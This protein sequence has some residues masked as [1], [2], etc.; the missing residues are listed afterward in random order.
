MITMAE[1]MYIKQLY[2]EGISK[3]EISKRTKLN[4]RTVSK[5]AEKRI[6]MI[7]RCPVLTRRTIRFSVNIYRSSTNGSKETPKYQESSVIRQNV[8]T[9]RLQEEYGY[10]GGYGSVK[11]Y[12]RK[13]RFVMHYEHTGCLPLEHPLISVF[14]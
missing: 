6:G 10:T 9:T 3:N 4:W 1:K 13:K 7:L 14:G 12:V 2:E 8:Y 11:R 5:Y